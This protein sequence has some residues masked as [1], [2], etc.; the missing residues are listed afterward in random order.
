MLEDW[1]PEVVVVV[2][3]AVLTG[4]LALVTGLLSFA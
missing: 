1:G 2:V 4:W 3:A